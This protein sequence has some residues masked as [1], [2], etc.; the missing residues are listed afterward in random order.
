MKN[1][2]KLI[3]IVSI[4]VLVLSVA[5][6]SYA[7]YRS[8]SK[9][10][11][12]LRTAAWKIK[13]NNN[14]ITTSNTFSF[15]LNDAE[16]THSTNITPTNNTIATIAPGSIGT[17]ELEIDTDGTEVDVEYTISIVVKEGNNVVDLSSINPNLTIGLYS[18][19][20]LLSNPLND[21][22][23][24]GQSKD[25]AI[26]IIWNYVDDEEANTN[27]I[28]LESSNYSIEVT[29][30]TKQK[31]MTAAEKIS[32]T[33]GLVTNAGAKRY[34]GPNPD[35]YVYFNCSTNSIEEMNDSTCEK[36]RIIGV[37]DDQLK[38]IKASSIGGF[39]YRDDWWNDNDWE[40]GSLNSYLNG[41]YYNN[42]NNNAKSLIDDGIWYTGACDGLNL[43]ANT[44][45]TC[46]KGNQSNNKIGIMSYYEFLYAAES[47]CYNTSAINYYNGCGEN[48]WLYQDN[49]TDIWT[50]T[51]NS[52]N[53]SAALAIEDKGSINL[54]GITSNTFDVYPSL[55]L[56][57]TVKL[58]EGTGK[59]NNP[60]KLQ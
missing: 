4:L 6:S 60:Y 36:W 37:Y 55:Y 25:L 58:A 26:K 30:T 51:P 5:I 39:E 11:S 35:N 13:V 27:D 28:N 44:A 15:N 41:D 57:P 10:T 18:N 8:S 50:I 47:T 20:E 14:S 38:I 59:E 52:R 46:A 24:A 2:N 12:K 40:T 22:I 29:V 42:L 23:K 16:W 34:I 32:A 9:G 17:Y 31:P 7:I 53:S 1:K 3:M 48:D 49:G 33:K 56:K 19:D 45:Y 43:S 54:N 21:Y